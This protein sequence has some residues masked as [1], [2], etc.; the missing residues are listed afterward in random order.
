LVTKMAA[1][2]TWPQSALILSLFVLFA[3]TRSQEVLDASP[4]LLETSEDLKSSSNPS[5]F[6]SPFDQT[7]VSSGRDSPA[8]PPPFTSFGRDTY[9]AGEPLAA[10][11]DDSYYGADSYGAPLSPVLSTAPAADYDYSTGTGY[12]A[13]LAPVVSYEYE[14]AATVAPT[15]APTQ[16]PTTFA[17]TTAAVVPEEEVNMMD[18]IILGV[19]L[20]FFLWPTAVQID[21]GSREVSPLFPLP[22]SLPNRRRSQKRQKH[23]KKPNKKTTVKPTTEAESSSETPTTTATMVADITESEV[24]TIELVEEMEPRME[25]MEDPACQPHPSTL[26]SRLRALVWRTPCSTV[27]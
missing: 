20:L 19:I 14:Y 2:V 11:Q 21:P 4:L 6:I 23:K 3:S 5:S 26:I 13:P 24:E 9:Y 22:F 17:E 12:G 18:M 15:L 7:D 10:R 27:W 8:W 25:L 16:A 1:F